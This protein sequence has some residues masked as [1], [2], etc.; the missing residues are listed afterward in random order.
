MNNCGNTTVVLS[1][2]NVQRREIMKLKGKRFVE[3]E[4]VETQIFDWGTMKWLS[5]P[6]VTNAER[7]SFEVVIIQPGKGVMKHNHPIIEEVIYVVSGEGEQMVADER[8]QIKTGTLVHIPPNIYHETINTGWEPM[9]LV[10]I[11]APPSS[12]PE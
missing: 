5:E 12:G 7:F 8:R 3:P 9:K 1:R 2:L 11:Y 6:N 4:E 10:V